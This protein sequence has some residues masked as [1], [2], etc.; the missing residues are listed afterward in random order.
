MRKILYLLLS[1]CVNFFWKKVIIYKKIKGIGKTIYYEKAQHLSFLF[2]LQICYEHLLQRKI[3]YYINAGDLVFD[4]GGN[5]GQY[6]L[7]FSE[8]V[9]E[10]GKVISFEPDFKSFSYLQFNSNINK[11]SNLT[12]LNVG[13]GAVDDYLK[14]Y[15]DVQT[16][17]RKG[18]FIE[19]FTD[20]TSNNNSTETVGIATFNTIVKEF[21]KPAFVKIDVEG[22][23]ENILKGLTLSLD[24]TV[25]LIEV[26][27]QT[28][29]FV[30][31][32]FNYREFSCFW[33]DNKDD[34]KI[35]D[36]KD[37]PEFANLIFLK[38]NGLGKNRM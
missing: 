18:S 8:L 4:I 26:R 12:C 10:N 37:I 22:S 38:T 28:K 29:D 7:L 5:I 1:K 13:V 25:F 34:V 33:I 15:R 27:E 19:K 36:S 23:E 35:S 3:R 24:N 17:G 6:A 30:F 20:G 21:G 16:G 11:C 9:G 31:S 2:Q 32:Y 14:F